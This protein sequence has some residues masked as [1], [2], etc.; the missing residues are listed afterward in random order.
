MTQFM[1]KFEE[2][3][4]SDIVNTVI[5]HVIEI[6]LSRSLS[7]LEIICINVKITY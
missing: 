6:V 2:V 4:E 7:G 1:D 3:S 5:S